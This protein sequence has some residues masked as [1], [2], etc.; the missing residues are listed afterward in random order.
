MG[1]SVST[2]ATA[3]AARLDAF[4]QPIAVVPAP[5]PTRWLAI[6]MTGTLTGYFLM[7]S[8]WEHRICLMLGAIAPLLIIRWRE[9]AHF[10][11]ASRL[12]V[13]GLIFQGWMAVSFVMNG[14]PPGALEW[15]ATAGNMGLLMAFSCASASLAAN[16]DWL[17]RVRDWSIAAAVLAAVVS[18]FVYWV[19]GSPM[20]IGARLRNWFVH[21]GQHPVP[22]GIEFAWAAAFA[23]VAAAADPP[24]RARRLHLAAVA[25]LTLAVC[26]TQTRGA[27]LGLCAASAALLLAQRFS[28]AA[29][30]PVAVGLAMFG[31]FQIAAPPLVKAS[32]KRHAEAP[33][34]ASISD[35]ARLSEKPLRQLVERG[36]SG[37]LALYRQ[38]LRRLDKPESLIFGLGWWQP[39]R[40]VPPDLHWR[41]THPHSVFISTL[42]HGGQAGLVLFCI[43]LGEAARRAWRLAK[44][45]R[46]ATGATLLVFGVA[47]LLFDGESAVTFLTEPRFEPLVLWFAIGLLAVPVPEDAEATV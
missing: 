24:G 3:H 11:L 22:T 43:F 40:S 14:R 6:G 16:R 7:P 18:I 30:R 28:I 34:L 35:A 20:T 2:M 42:Y 39:H 26:C 25:V 47:T 23:A 37:R 8:G 13:L 36:D 17:H 46:S 32:M 27:L 4:P 44:R 33:P 5:F 29:L 1:I 21:G 31:L 38:L 10:F 45:H 19:M 41:A 15:L 9:A 12:L